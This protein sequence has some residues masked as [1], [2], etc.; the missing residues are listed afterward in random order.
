RVDALHQLV[1]RVMVAVYWFHPL[2]WHGT[3][4]AAAA[5]ESAC[6]EA[7]LGLG[8]RPSHYARHLVDLAEHGRA[9]PSMPA[10][11]RIHHPDLEDRVMAIL[12][13]PPAPLSSRRT[14]IAVSVLLLWTALV[15]A[16]RPATAQRPAE[17]VIPPA[18]AAP[19]L[20][21]VASV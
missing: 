5:R 21:V 15:A 18:P 1:A 6:D 9:M 13:Y 17:P 16:A 14:A 7:V 10:L 12:P 19:G 11:A 4:R 8:A 2:A 3:H 20:D